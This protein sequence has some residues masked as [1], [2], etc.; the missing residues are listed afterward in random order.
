L[1]SEIDYPSGFTKKLDWPVKGQ[2]IKPETADT[3][4][5]MLTTVFDNYD[6]GKIKLD[7]YSIAA[8]TGT[9][10]IAHH[11]TVDITRIETCTRLWRIFLLKI[12]NLSSSCITIIQKWCQLFI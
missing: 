5:K 11:A 1:V 6:G 10:Q 9:A 7:H 3:I 12:L 4:T 8:K 2:L